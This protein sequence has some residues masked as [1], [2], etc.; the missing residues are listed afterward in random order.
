[1]VLAISAVMPA[2]AAASG[3]VPLMPS[4][5]AFPNQPACVAELELLHKLERAEVTDGR[6]RRSDGT[7][8]QVKL[9][10]DGL[11]D[12]GRGATLYASRIWHHHGWPD[13]ASG[14]LKLSHSYRERQRM[15]AAG[16]L[17]ESGRDGFTQH[18]FE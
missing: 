9:E 8:R 4:T 6:V 14:K 17:S 16:T 1:M 11:R 15:C 3:S 10:T 5:R 12:N 7:T 13:A 2:M 18:T